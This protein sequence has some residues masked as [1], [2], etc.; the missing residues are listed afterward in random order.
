MGGFFSTPELCNAESSTPADSDASSTEL[1]AREVAEQA[2]A[3]ANAGRPGDAAGLFRW[4]WGLHNHW[5]YICNAAF[6]EAQLGRHRDAA[7]SL[8]ACERDMPDE[9]RASLGAKVARGLKSVLPHVASLNVEANV[10]G[11]QLLIDGMVVDTLPV[12]EPIFVEPGTREIIVRKPNYH[13]DY[14]KIDLG[15]GSHLRLSMR[16][17]PFENRQ[18]QSPSLAGRVVDSP[19]APNSVPAGDEKRML[20]TLFGV[21]TGIGVGSAIFAATFGV[22]TIIERVD[23]G[24]TVDRLRREHGFL[25]CTTPNL[26]GCKE[27]KEMSDRADVFTGIFIASLATGG[28]GLA[29]AVYSRRNAQEPAVNAAVVPTPGGGALVVRGR[30]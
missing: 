26:P 3:A 4:A 12:D 25:P 22:A 14:K 2:R 19:R 1:H 21:G 6:L 23:E 28:A 8:T 18:A 24:E 27:Y 20:R 29:M 30:F 15:G 13:D 9:L 17:I 16:L 10:S 11:A 5:D 7:A